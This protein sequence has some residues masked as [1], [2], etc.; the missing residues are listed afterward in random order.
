[1]QKSAG[2][3][4]MEAQLVQ[5]HHIEA[6]RDVLNVARNA[7]K[8]QLQS[9]DLSKHEMKSILRKLTSLTDVVKHQRKVVTKANKA[10]GQI[11]YSK[12]VH[13]KTQQ[14]GCFSLTPMK[15]TKRSLI[16]YLVN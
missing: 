3:K 5:H 12:Y 15:P 10:T 1:M 11:R 14:V 7:V 9:E 16:E 6:L 13:D 4:Q 2:D 8:N